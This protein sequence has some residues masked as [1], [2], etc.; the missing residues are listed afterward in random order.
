MFLWF[1]DLK[2]SISCSNALI[3]YK[4]MKLFWTYFVLV[5]WV[6]LVG[7]QRNLF[8]SE[9]NTVIIIKTLVDPSKWSLTDFTSKAKAISLKIKHLLS[10]MDFS[11]TWQFHLRFIKLIIVVYLLCSEVSILV[12]IVKVPKVAFLFSFLVWKI[13]V[14]LLLFFLFKF[15]LRLWPFRFFTVF[16]L[17]L[18]I[19][20][21][22]P[23]F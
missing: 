23:P 12:I 14:S 22:L 21:T 13:W 19:S 4:V 20:Q 5:S 15:V 18:T 8:N 6:K 9:N 2:S 16:W 17:G 11:L 10:N 1:R 3:F 7:C